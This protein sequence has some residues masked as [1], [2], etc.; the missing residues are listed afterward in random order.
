VAR[1]AAAAQLVPAELARL[2]FLQGAVADPGAAGVS[3]ASIDAAV[4]SFVL[5]LVPDRE[6][7]LA[8]LRDALVPG[9][10]LAFV[11]WASEAKPWAAEVA[12][13]AALAATLE[14]AGMVSPAP[15]GGSRAGPI[16]SAAAARAELLAARF[17]EVDAWEPS[18]HHP[19][20]RDEARALFLEYDRTEELDALAP[21][22]RDAVVAAFDAKLARLPERA[23]LWD[24][25]LV[26]A[27]ATR[28][29]DD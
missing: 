24:A 25:P 20:T 12:F 14:N 22:V 23:L 2:V 7:A 4:S 16:R 26:A 21:G 29:P 1:A 9:G 6:A 13:E 11:L 28:P 5:H 27:R 3:P 18:L 10:V 8:G 15:A 17:A 19:F